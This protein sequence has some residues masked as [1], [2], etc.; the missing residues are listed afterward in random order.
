[1]AGLCNL[2]FTVAV[3]S[4]A[5]SKWG[6]LGIIYKLLLILGCSLFTVIQPLIIYRK[7]CRQA[8]AIVHETHISFDDKGVHVRLG[9]ES[10]DIKWNKL[11]RVSKKP[12][13]IVLF[14]DASH[15][16]VLS[17][18]ILGSEKEAFYRYVSARMNQ[19]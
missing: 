10:S 1:M 9:E 2:I 5:V 14:T 3:A 18:R 16:Y 19:G 12:G 8:A 11:L 7:A 6:T 4:L 17:N 15:G 13:M